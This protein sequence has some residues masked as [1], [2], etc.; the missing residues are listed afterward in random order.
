MFARAR[1]KTM[2]FL[3][4]V[5]ALLSRVVIRCDVIR[6]TYPR[7]QAHE[8]K[9]QK[10][11]AQHSAAHS[12]PIA[13]P[14]K[15]PSVREAAKIPPHRTFGSPA[16]AKA[17]APAAP[18][19]R[20]PFTPEPPESKFPSNRAPSPAATKKENEKKIKAPTRK[21]PAPTSGH[22]A[23]GGVAMSCVNHAACP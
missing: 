15:S 22:A 10:R 13:N 6:L 5:R 14:V 4:R 1:V 21:A 2:R 11:L 3:L 19:A 7:L 23:A 9:K 17:P 12:S 16:P 8:V 20:P 18:P